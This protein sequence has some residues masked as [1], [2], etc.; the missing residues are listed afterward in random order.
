MLKFKS[1]DLAYHDKRQMIYTLVWLEN[2]EGAKYPVYFPKE[3]IDKPNAELYEAAMEIIYQEIF[4]QRAENERF[5]KIDDRLLQFDKLAISNA[6]TIK[7][8]DAQLALSN[9]L[10]SS[11]LKVVMVLYEKGLLSDEELL[12]TGLF[13]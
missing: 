6:E 11:F 1:K 9:S 10:R 3:D 12:K 2:D 5:S 4:P 13:E 8:M 7:K